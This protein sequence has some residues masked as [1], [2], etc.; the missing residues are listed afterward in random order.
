LECLKSHA[1]QLSQAFCK[2][3]LC[4]CKMG[5]LT[6]KRGILT[7]VN[8]KKIRDIIKKLLSCWVAKDQDNNLMRL[9][10]QV[11]RTTSIQQ[12]GNVPM[13]WPSMHPR[14]VV[15][16]PVFEFS[17]CTLWIL[18]IQSMG[19]FFFLRNLSSFINYINTNLAKFTCN[20][21]HMIL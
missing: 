20:I 18:T 3:S 7:L 15:S 11:A 12:G 6:V 16:L 9:I 13:F 14:E 2:S 4:K 21:C 19:L 8:Q 17:I 10:F 5:T 1:T